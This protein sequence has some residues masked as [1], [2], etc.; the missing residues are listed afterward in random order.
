MVFL[1]LPDDD[2]AALSVRLAEHDILTRGRRWVVHLDVS[3]DDVDR[4]ADV[5]RNG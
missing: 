1:N 3:E 2:L 4:V 5:I